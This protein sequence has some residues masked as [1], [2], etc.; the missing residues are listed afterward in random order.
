MLFQNQ[1]NQKSPSGS[2]RNDSESVNQSLDEVFGQEHL[3]SEGA[4]LRRL[5]DSQ[6][7]RSL[8]F[9]GPPGTGKTSSSRIIARSSTRQIHELTAVSDGVAAIKS[10]IKKSITDVEAGN[11]AHILFID[12]IHRLSR[13]QQDVLLPALENSDILMIGATTENP[14]FEINRAVLSRS[15]V[16]RFNSLKKADVLSALKHAVQKLEKHSVAGALL[17]A[18]A[19]STGGDVRKAKML[20]DAIIAMT[21]AEELHLVEAIPPGLDLSLPS[22]DKDREQHYQTASAMIK[23]IRASHPDA[24]CFYLSVMLEGGEDINFITRRLL[25]SASEDIGNADPQALILANS[26]AQAVRQVGMPESK[27][28]L[29][30]LVCYMAAAPKSNSSYLAIKEA[31]LAITQ[32]KTNATP[33]DFIAN[34]ASGKKTYASPHTDR[35]QAYRIKSY[36]PVSYNGK[37]RFYLPK[38]TGYEAT[39]IQRLKAQMPVKDLD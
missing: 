7:F 35:E 14:S 5:I 32:S 12:E 9:W 17:E 29:S 23:C 37:R 11:S 8:I 28:L 4:S 19:S 30:Q 18:I 34:S 22:Y 39:M 3:F 26:C 33:P 16:F 2:A 24:A 1:E 13:S 15:F 27:I 6:A 21:P 25:I 31:T 38:G 10:A 20:L 36:F